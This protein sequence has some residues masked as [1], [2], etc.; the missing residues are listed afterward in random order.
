MCKI[1]NQII[2]ELEDNEIVGI[3]T[4]ND[5]YDSM[6]FGHVRNYT[7]N[8]IVLG[9]Y[10]D[11]GFAMPEEKILLTDIVSIE[12][13]TA[14][15]KYLE[16]LIMVREHLDYEEKKVYQED[17]ILRTIHS[18]HFNNMMAWFEIL[19][20]NFVSGYVVGYNKDL[21]IIM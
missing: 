13:N 16:R 7:D 4:I 9:I 6:L 21:V 2:K 3:R 18:L 12:T 17:E 1:K 5:T 20:D 8:N 15:C 14:Y 19:A 10:D 11:R